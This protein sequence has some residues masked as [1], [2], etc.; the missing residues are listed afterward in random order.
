[1]ED[2]ESHLLQLK[3]DEHTEL[4]SGARKLPSSFYESYSAFANTDGGDI[5]IGIGE[6]EPNLILGVAN[7]EEQIKSML[8]TLEN[9]QKVSFN[10]I[11]S[12]DYEVLDV[13]G[14]KIIKV[15]VN[16]APRHEKP[17][18]LNG[19]PSNSYKRIGDGD[20]RMLENEVQ[21]KLIDRDPTS[22]DM[23]VNSFGFGIED[24]DADS[25]SK[26]RQRLER[27]RPDDELDKLSDKELLTR[28]GAY[29][30]NRDGNF[31]LT[32]AAILFFGKWQDIIGIYPYYF[33]DYQ[34]FDGSGMERWA[35]RFSSNEL[36]WPG[37]IFCFYLKVEETIRQY[38]PN[39]FR[40]EG[41]TNYEGRD[42]LE[43]CLE[44][45]INAL[46]NAS[47][48]LPTGVTVKQAPN[49]FHVDNPGGILV[50]RNQALMGGLSIPRNPAIL[51]F[52]RLIGVAEKS[53]LGIPKVFTVAAR[54]GFPTPSLSERKDVEMTSMHVSFLS[55]PSDAPSR[56]LKLRVISYLAD[57]RQGSDAMTIARDLDISTSQSSLIVRE[58]ISSGILTTNNKK[59][60]G[61]KIFLSEDY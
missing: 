24:L 46:S 1:M 55:L 44:V 40:R 10:T 11:S 20:V 9:K 51:S 49:Y 3:E 5:Y 14:K 33:L 54:Y 30:K 35:R 38:L 53:G 42:I 45:L 59:K 22:R 2:I 27:Y 6:G 41:D 15:S 34:Y 43:A 23:L 4:K 61:R 48:F 18:Y 37:N 58:L 28:I 60:R 57:K 25:L 39:P 7:P 31:G 16:E 21:S 26:Y 50:G 19:S 29:R 32:N 36:S 8:S 47:Y 56:E 13:A 17:V 12:G 52:F